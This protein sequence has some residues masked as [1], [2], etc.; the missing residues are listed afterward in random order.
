MSQHSVQDRD[1]DLDLVRAHDRWPRHVGWIGLVSAAYI[2]T[3]MIVEAFA[4]VPTFTDPPTVIREWFASGRADLVV[5]VAGAG[6]LVTDLLLFLPFVL[7]SGYVL[8]RAVPHEPV[9]P[10]L[11]LVGGVMSVP[12][13]WISSMFGVVIHVVS[14]QQLSDATLVTL[15]A[16]DNYAFGSMVNVSIALWI[17]AG[18]LA[19]LR[20][21]RFPRWVGWLGVGG[22][23]AL[24]VSALWFLQG[25][26]QGTLSS[27]GAL[28]ILA[29]VVWMV[30]LA[31]SLI[32]HGLGGPV[33]PGP[34]GQEA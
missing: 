17:G 9:L 13:L 6:D 18:G 30:T 20:S 28:G 2:V 33:A 23:I 5:A 14:H 22:G 4:R 29:M 7:G 25:D 21:R 34:S 3:V 26:P 15:L 1:V 27:V 24:I 12:L 32:R 11:S 16:L 19:I 8:R 31:L 10:L